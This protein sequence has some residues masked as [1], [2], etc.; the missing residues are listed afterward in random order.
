VGKLTIKQGAFVKAYLLNNGNATQAAIDAGYSTKTAQVIGAENLLKPI[1]ASSIKEHQKITSG[2][3]V[4]SKEEKLKLLQ[5]VMNKC[6]VDDDEKG[7]LN[8]PSVIA[9]IKEHNLMQ[10]DNAPVETS[11][12]TR[13][14]MPVPTADSTESWEVSSAAVH[15][16]NLNV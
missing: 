2:D 15:L 12:V 14:I 10:G 7:M 9:A 13:N 3:F 8:A 6:S 4:F 16:R 5:K 11:T 1:I